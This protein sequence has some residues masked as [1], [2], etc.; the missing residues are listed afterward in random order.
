MNRQ[1][2]GSMPNCSANSA[3]SSRRSSRGSAVSASY[4]MMG[5]G[6]YHSGA[7]SLP[8]SRRES[9]NSILNPASMGPGASYESSSNQPNTAGS[10]LQSIG[11]GVVGA[12]SSFY[13]TTASTPS[14]YRKARLRP[15]I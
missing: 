5:G 4:I 7:S 11:S 8:G 1:L 10:I 2:G 9:I 15:Q 3:C 14:R 12:A 13:N 6:G